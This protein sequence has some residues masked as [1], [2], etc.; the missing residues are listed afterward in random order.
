M[1]LSTAFSLPYTQIRSSAAVL[2]FPPYECSSWDVPVGASLVTSFGIIA[3]EHWG[4][5]T[6]ENLFSD[7]KVLQENGKI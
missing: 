5:A 4:F 6:G 1:L 2:V 7:N 3:V